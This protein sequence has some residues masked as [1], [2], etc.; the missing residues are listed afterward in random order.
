MHNGGMLLLC[1]GEGRW[2]GVGG[3]GGQV[4][5]RAGQS[6]GRKI[7]YVMQKR[8]AK[9]PNGKIAQKIEAF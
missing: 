3:G 1:E 4:S 7:C 8:K 2:G 6:Q 9:S 5:E